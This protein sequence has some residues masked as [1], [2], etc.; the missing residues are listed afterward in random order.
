MSEQTEI[1]QRQRFV[2]LGAD[3]AVDAQC[4]LQIR[5]GLHVGAHSGYTFEKPISITIH[6]SDGD[7]VGL[8]EEELTLYRW[9]GDATAWEDAA[10]A[11]ASTTA[12]PTRT[13]WPS[14]YAT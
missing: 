5:L 6:Y 2:L 8:D 10:C 3:L 7:V 14:P 1:A 13:G 12:I 9:D 4:L 11:A